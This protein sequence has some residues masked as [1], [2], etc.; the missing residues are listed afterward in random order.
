MWTLADD[1][2]W[3]AQVQYRPPGTHT[4]VIGTFPA[5]RVREDTVDRSEGR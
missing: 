1:G 4:R 3:T 2:T 5:E